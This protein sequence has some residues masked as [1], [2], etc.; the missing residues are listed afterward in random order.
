MH[1]T[2]EWADGTGRR[3]PER[4]PV[5]GAR[6]GRAPF[7]AAPRVLGPG[8]DQEMAGLGDS[9]GDGLELT[10]ADG[11][12]AGDETGADGEPGSA[13]TVAGGSPL[14]AG[15]PVG[16][17][18]VSSDAVPDALGR[19]LLESDGLAEADGSAEPP[20]VAAPAGAVV[21]AAD[22]VLSSGPGVVAC[23]AGGAEVDT[24]GWRIGAIGGRFGSGS[25][26]IPDTQA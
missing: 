21:D 15:L 23:R 9:T 17:P 14:A 5:H 26:V 8:R 25:G 19:G 3:A 18:T 16:F 4:G 2:R 7:G 12:S 24:P 20:G 22:G 10:G 1:G 11:L 13:G 6:A